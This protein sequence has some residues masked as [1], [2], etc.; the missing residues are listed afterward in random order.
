MPYPNE[1]S[2]RLLSPEVVIQCRRTTRISDNRKYG[3]ITCEYTAPVTGGKSKWAEQAFRYPIDI[4]T[5]GQAKNHCAKHK[6]KFEPAKK[7][8]EKSDLPPGRF[9]RKQIIIKTQSGIFIKD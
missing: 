3:V 4:W 2:C 6:G 7:P 9:V 1:H 8:I 5:E